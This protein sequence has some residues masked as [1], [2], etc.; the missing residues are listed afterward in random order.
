MLQK[1][2]A[3]LAL[4]NVPLVLMIPAAL[5]VKEPKIKFIQELEIYANVL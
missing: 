2:V 5:L 3:R 1:R 4:S